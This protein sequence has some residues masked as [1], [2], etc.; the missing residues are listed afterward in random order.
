M[1]N[2]KNMLSLVR[3]IAVT[4][5]WL[6]KLVNEVSVLLNVVYNYRFGQKI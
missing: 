3:D 5:Y 6:A 1:K 4:S 2:F